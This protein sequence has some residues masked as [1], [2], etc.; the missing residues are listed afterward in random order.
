LA[1]GQA[2]RTQANAFLEILRFPNELVRAEFDSVHV[3]DR[4][5]AAVMVLLD[6]VLDWNRAGYDLYEPVSA[7]AWPSDSRE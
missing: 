6:V 2:D 5:A 1:L 3:V 4:R 7:P